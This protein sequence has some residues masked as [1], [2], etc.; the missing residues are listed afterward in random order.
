ME[1]YQSPGP[2]SFHPTHESSNLCA[3]CLGSLDHPLH[4]EFDRQW[5]HQ[6]VATWTQEGDLCWSVKGSLRK[7]GRELQN[8]RPLENG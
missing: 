8:P 6:P 3:L 1:N 7:M 2:L 5:H 4:P